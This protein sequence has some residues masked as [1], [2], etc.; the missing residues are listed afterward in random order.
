MFGDGFFR[1]FRASLEYHQRHGS[2]VPLRVRLRDH[3]SLSHTGK[4]DNVVFQIDR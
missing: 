3:A 1:D 4:P 2:L